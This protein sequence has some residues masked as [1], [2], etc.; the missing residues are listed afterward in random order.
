MQTMESRP[1]LS[2]G[3]RELVHRFGGQEPSQRA[4]EFLVDEFLAEKLCATLAAP[5]ETNDTFLLIERLI[6]DLNTIRLA[7]E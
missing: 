1:D 6:D 5:D 4:A 3:V 2:P 7:D